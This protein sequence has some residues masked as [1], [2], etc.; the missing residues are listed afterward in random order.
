MKMS[1]KFH[2][3]LTLLCSDQFKTFWILVGE[4]NAN[5]VSVGRGGEEVPFMSRTFT[6]RHRVKYTGDDDD[7]DDDT[8]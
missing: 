5:T 2:T 3:F 4:G 7:D 8:G 1:G 6:R